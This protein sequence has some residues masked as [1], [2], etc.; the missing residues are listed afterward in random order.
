MRVA[1]R[2]IP[3]RLAAAAA[4]IANARATR[5][6]APPISNILE[7]LAST[8]PTILEEVLEDAELALNAAEQADPRNIPP[9]FETLHTP[10]QARIA[11]LEEISSRLCARASVLVEVDYAGTAW[12][13]TWAAAPGTPSRA[14]AD[15]GQ[16]LYQRGLSLV[17]F[18]TVFGWG[19][20]GVPLH[21]THD[22]L[23][24]LPESERARALSYQGRLTP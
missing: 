14:I 23:M 24:R 15:W 12:V 10:E 1:D 4:A 6:G 17:P 19:N 5:R 20:G 3:G 18:R 16:S 13:T 22:E 8:A 2:E 9:R 7:L 11:A 21:L